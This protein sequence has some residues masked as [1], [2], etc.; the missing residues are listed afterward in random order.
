MVVGKEGRAG[1]FSSCWEAVERVLN[2]VRMRDDSLSSNDVNMHLGRVMVGE[3][4]MARPERYPPAALSHARASRA[5]DLKRAGR[6]LLLENRVREARGALVK[7]LRARPSP[8]L[9]LLLALSLAGPRV[10][11]LVLGARQAPGR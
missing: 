9:A 6:Q 2:L 8:K 11:R 1:F 3:R 10:C 5:V 4:V 7:S